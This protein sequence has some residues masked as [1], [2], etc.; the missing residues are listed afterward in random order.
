MNETED[1][2]LCAIREVLEETGYDCSRLLKERHFLE[3]TQGEGVTRLYIV[4][5]VQKDYDFKPQ[6]RKEIRSIKWFPLKVWA[7]N[8]FVI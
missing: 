1:P 7:N 8:N 3:H 4:P 2:H 5:G 6:T